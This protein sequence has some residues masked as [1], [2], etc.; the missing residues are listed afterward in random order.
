MG[1]DSLETRNKFLVTMGDSSAAVDAFLRDFN[2]ISG[3]SRTQS[4]N[5]L[6]D[7]AANS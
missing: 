5:L 4:E 7:M 2:K 6:A 3:L 1:S